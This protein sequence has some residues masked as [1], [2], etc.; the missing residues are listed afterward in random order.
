MLGRKD[1]KGVGSLQL[2]FEPGN[3]CGQRGFQILIVH[4]QIVDPD[5]RDREFFRGKFGKRLG[6][7][8]IDGVAAIASDHDSNIDLW[9]V[10]PHL[11]YTM[12]LGL[13]RCL[14]TERKSAHRCYPV[15]C[16][17]PRPAGP[18]ASFSTE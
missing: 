1:E 13:N 8:A 14:T 5:E 9:H 2:G 18:S 12:I 11:S 16:M 7:L 3:V 10:L 6:K 15:T 17:S 4:G